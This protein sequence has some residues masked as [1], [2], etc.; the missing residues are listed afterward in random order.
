[1]LQYLKK[2]Y[3]YLTSLSIPDDALSE[4]SSAVNE[5]IKDSRLL[6]AAEKYYNDIF[7]DKEY[8]REIMALTDEYADGKIGEGMIFTVVMLLR[9][10]IL[11]SVS[12]TV[13]K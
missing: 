1:M 6:D 5:C 12:T 13:R 3:D 2:L 11:T 8:G 9:A 7:S 4:V 10:F